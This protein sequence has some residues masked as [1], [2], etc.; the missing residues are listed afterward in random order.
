MK[1][2]NEIVEILSSSEGVLSEAL[3]KT[4][5]LLYKIGHKELVIWVNKE[6]NG[7]DDN[8]ELPDYRIVQAQV[9][10]NASNQGYQVSNH[11]IPLGHLDKDYREQLERGKMPQSLAVIEK[12]VADEDA[13]LRSPIPMEANTLLGK[14]LANNYM[15]QSAWCEIQITSVA[16]ILVQVRSRLLDFV[17]ELSTEYMSANSDDEV[18]DISKK[19][20]AANLF[21]NA[22]FGDNATIVVGSDNSQSISNSIEKNNF[23]SLS[24][25]LRKHDVSKPDIDL[26]EIAIERDNKV[27]DLKKNNF[28][29]EVQLWMKEMLSKAID[30]S[31]KVEL[32]VA[33]SLLA[34]ALN[35]YYGLV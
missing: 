4:K 3:I 33:S 6:I 35:N 13:S 31:W 21:N 32:G 16:N 15:I 14:G 18:N 2:I 7:Y 27:I 10:V 9:L 19:L 29:P 8:D 28:G 24:E 34:T 17:L 11:P 23:A 1:L 5:V 20:D 30:T 12:F 22:I 26:L 25:E